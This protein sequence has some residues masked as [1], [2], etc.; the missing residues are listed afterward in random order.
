MKK[1]F[2]FLTIML[3]L[4][5]CTVKDVNTVK[6]GDQDQISRLSDLIEDIDPSYDENVVKANISLTSTNLLELLP[7]IDDT[8][9]GIEV[10]DSSTVESVEIFTSQEKGGSNPMDRVFI[11]LA[12]KFNR[13]NKKI[14]NGKKAA[15]SVRGIDSGAGMAFILANKNVPEA[16]SPSNELWIKMIEAQGADLKLIREVTTPNVPGIVVKKDKM[17]LITT[18]GKV[19]IQKLLT[20]VT[21]GNFAMGYT[22]PFKSDT[23]LNM[24]LTILNGFAKGDES[25]MLTP[26]VS[27]AFEAF[28]LG[29]PFV[30]ETTLQMRDA[31]MNSG[32]LDAFV[33]EYQT[34][35]QTK[36]WG[37]YQFIPFGVRHDNPLYATEEADADEL[38]VL[39]LFAKYIDK[40]KA[41]LKKY[42]FGIGPD[43]KDT[44]E[45]KDGSTI[46]QAQRIWKENKS[47]GKPI[48]AMF[49]ADVSGSMAG[50]RIASLK[51][52]L[53]DASGLISANN[54]IGLIAFNSRVNVSVPIRQFNINQKAQFVGAVQGL[55]E[56]GGTATNDAILVALDELT[57]F[58]EKNPDHRLTVFVLSDGAQTEGYSLGRIQGVIKAVGIPVHTMAY[59]EGINP[60]ELQKIASL[61]EA[62]FTS[63]TDDSASYNIGNLLNSQM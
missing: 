18:N 10:K 32:V 54:A 41:T 17:D 57:K 22:N 21:G 20:E 39:E 43:H 29:V 63:S 38:E 53:E 56:G 60:T 25:A 31:T 58:G 47:G 2:S 28:Q 30:A 48:A 35:N 8:P 42:G 45:I 33:M 44:Y 59:G 62:S 11:D 5:S 9:L 37:E 52:A 24:V 15:V 40:N 46:I 14:S 1:I 6:V 50:N 13:E 27:S 26:A 3:L 61:V 51:T 19:D 12:E 16:Y 4:F 34:F 23:G 55:Q 49:V 7:D 36:S